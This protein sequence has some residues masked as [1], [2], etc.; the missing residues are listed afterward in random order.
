MIGGV[1]Q[2]QARKFFSHFQED[3]ILKTGRK[4]PMLFGRHKNVFE[5]LTDIL[6]VSKLRK[7]IYNEAQCMDFKTRVGGN[8]NVISPA[9]Q[10]SNA[11]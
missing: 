8:W 10:I 3:Q 9:Y 4:K 1:V 7:Q 11:K 6:D 5:K 2:T